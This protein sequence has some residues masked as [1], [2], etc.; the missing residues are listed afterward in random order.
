M[1]PATVRRAHHPHARFHQTPRQQEA[2]AGGVAPVLVA[3]LGRFLVK[4]KRV[5]RFRR[6]NHRVGAL[7]KTIHARQRIALFHRAEMAVHNRAHA[8]ALVETLGVDTFWQG[9]IPHAEIGVARIRAQAER[10]ERAAE[11]T[12]AA[13][14][15]LARDSHVGR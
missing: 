7:I 6:G 8:A 14:P 1:I 5:A 4:I 2:A 15:A 3:Q 12:R 13:I 11:I 9:K 10:A